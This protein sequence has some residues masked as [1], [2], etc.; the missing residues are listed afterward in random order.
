MD[1]SEALK[2]LKN[3][4]QMQVVGQEW[5]Y[6]C[7]FNSVLI[8]VFEGNKPVEA[9]LTSADIFGEWKKFDGWER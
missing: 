5:R 6:F 8:S 1:F 2:E 9:V 7:L 3:G 4:R